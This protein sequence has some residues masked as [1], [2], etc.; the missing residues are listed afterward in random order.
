[1]RPLCVVLLSIVLEG[2]CTSVYVARSRSSQGDFCCAVHFSL[3][4]SS[5]GS[6]PGHF[7][8]YANNPEK[9][10]RYEAVAAGQPYVRPP[11]ESSSAYHIGQIWASESKNSHSHEHKTL[12]KQP[13][14]DRARTQRK[15]AHINRN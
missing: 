5:A 15:A 2:M 12:P 8:P 11:S 6:G 14:R 3:C 9:Q 1:M 4:R 7:K 13:K 10:Q